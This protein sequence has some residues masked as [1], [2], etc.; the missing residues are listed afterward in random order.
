MQI[1]KD[2]ISK[3]KNSDSKLLAVTKY[4]NINEIRE[5]ISNFNEDELEILVWFW[6]NRVSSLKEKN[7]DREQTHFI[8]NIQ[9]KEIKYIVKY[10]STIHSIDNI[11]Q[12]KKINEICEKQNSWVKVFIQ[13]KIDET[14]IGWIDVSEIPN[15]LEIINNSENIWLVW[16]SAIWKWEFSLD[17]KIDEFKLLKKLRDKYIPNWIISAWTSRDYEIAL[18]QWIEIIRVGKSLTSNL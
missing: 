2:L 18:E 3:F 5:F 11:K 6:E 4:W 9:T 8:G 1:N 13:I 7:L 16:F 15:F 17:E 14:K 12:I 10:C